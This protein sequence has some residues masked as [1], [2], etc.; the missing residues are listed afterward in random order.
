MIRVHWPFWLVFPIAGIIPA[1]IAFTFGFLGLKMKGT[2]FLFL[3]IALCG[4]IDWM[5]S[6]WVGLFR[7]N[8][9]YY[10]VP[11]PVI[12]IFGLTIR[13]STSLMPYYYLALILV[14]VTSL[15]YFK[16]HGSRLGRVW[17]NIGKNDGLLANLGI[18]VFSQK[19]IC[20]VASCFFAGL[21]GAVYA[22]YMTIVSPTQF[23]LWQ[24]IWIVLG[25]LVGGI[26]SPIG[27][28]IGT[29]FMAILNIATVNSRYYTCFS[30]I[31]HAFWS[32]WLTRED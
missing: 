25:V 3:T 10:P 17:D 21:A 24:G 7:G 29:V 20:L 27:A 31:I 28:I 5:W 19:Q 9:G 6:S 1:V 18:S 14:L 8:I 13:F 30:T 22:P 11:Q 12:R 4:L 15:F 23:T 2:Y 26:F 16:I 32:I